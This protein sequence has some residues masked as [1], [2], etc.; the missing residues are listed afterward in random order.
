M[1]TI[2]SCNS[3]YIVSRDDPEPER[4]RSRLDE[5]V[6]QKL[7]AALASAFG[8]GEPPD[9]GFW[10][11]RSLDVALAVNTAWDD[12][13]ISLRWAEGI[14]RSFSA[15]TSDGG[16][17]ALFFADRAAYLASY[18]V[19]CA[20]GS[21]AREWFFEPFS[22]F[23]ALPASAAVRSVIEEETEA[24]GT[25]LVR[26]PAADLEKVLSMLSDADARRILLAFGGRASAAP[27]QPASTSRP[28]IP[29]AAGARPATDF[30]DA[31]ELLLRT[32]SPP[33]RALS[34]P[35]EALFHYLA[36]ARERPDAAA[37]ALAQAA[38][39]LTRLARRLQAEGPSARALLAALAGGDLATL[40]VVAGAADAGALRALLGVAPETIWRIGRAV[41][42]QPAPLEDAQIT[43]ATA[44]FTRFG[45]AFLLLPYV[46]SLPLPAATDLPPPQAADPESA[47]RF[48][49][50]VR[51]FGAERF[52]AAFRDPLLRDL[53][54]I[55]PALSPAEAR[56]WESAVAAQSAA[57]WHPE[58]AR[59]QAAVWPE[60][61]GVFALE[62]L[63]GG[64][65]VLLDAESGVWR[66]RGGTDRGELAR[67]ETLLP[68]DAALHCRAD[69]L[70]SSAA[71]ALPG[72]RIRAGDAAPTF[73]R[74][75]EDAD[76]LEAE[77]GVAARIFAPAAQNALRAF[78]QRLP[79]F[80]RSGL[81]YL[82]RNFLDLTAS[83][84]EFPERRVVRLGRP[85]LDL[86]LSM[87]G[88]NRA[89]HRLRGPDARP[90][91]LYPQE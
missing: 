7:P 27:A 46:D 35:A 61:G 88:L 11:I 21:P 81:P 83:L 58:L 29:P 34:E 9:G 5:I 70:R 8:G 48:L 54:R 50:L 82:H 41:G 53:F 43:P 56:A 23:S 36:A 63:P 72:F 74:F 33:R 15:A 76:F 60:D 14:A 71:E 67:I 62:P 16:S 42:A 4:L 75:A 47:F 78:A 86:V 55:P 69:S 17:G 65:A 1:L 18:F 24:G 80:A 3:R 20:D 77:S 12:N 45:G 32:W 49:V 73:E 52:E 38:V 87:A 22:G 44:R 84:E 68:P 66:W 30:R 31:P 40:Y 13:E 85:P 26:M 28:D 59:W 79:G 2:G 91:E 57:G 25:A 51:C 19:R 10:F 6:R 89:S 39:A 37:M 90:F 64:E